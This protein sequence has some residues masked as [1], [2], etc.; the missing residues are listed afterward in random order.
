MGLS[1]LVFTFLRVSIRIKLLPLYSLTIDVFA[2]KTITCDE[3]LHTRSMGLTIH[4]L[5]FKPISVFE[6]L[7]A[8]S[9]PITIH[10]HALK[11]VSILKLFRA[12]TMCLSILV[13]TFLNVATFKVLG[14]LNSLA[15]NVLSFKDVSIAMEDLALSIPVP[16]PILALKAISIFEDLD[17]KAMG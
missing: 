17:P 1:I 3:I 5:S 7:G 13:L 12:E 9:I 8:F 10:I 15:I 4:V 11:S 2:L 16:L 6:D 14:T